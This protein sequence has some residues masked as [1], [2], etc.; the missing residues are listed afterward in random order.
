MTQHWM[1]LLA[2]GAVTFLYR[3]SCLGLVGRR[4]VDPRWS[5]VLRFVPPAAFAALVAPELFSRGGSLIHSVREPRLLAGALAA[6]V[7][8]KTRNVLATIAAGMAALHILQR[9]S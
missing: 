8:W 5:H 6:L 7:A 2:V 4:A 1:T 3:F 9:F